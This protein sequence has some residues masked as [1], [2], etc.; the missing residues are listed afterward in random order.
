MSVQ[1]ILDRVKDLTAAERQL[2]RE[3][4]ARHQSEPATADTAEDLERI[5]ALFDAGWC[6]GDGRPVAATI[7][8]A[9]YGRPA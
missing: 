2:V 5:R 8:Q 1:E 3:A 4:L 6:E 7:D 9:L